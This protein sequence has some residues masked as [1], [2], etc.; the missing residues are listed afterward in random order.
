MKGKE[1]SQKKKN[2]QIALYLKEICH[3]EIAYYSHT[4]VLSYLLIFI[5]QGACV[6]CVCVCLR[7][8]RER[9]REK[10]AKSSS[11][12]LSGVCLRVYLLSSDKAFQDKL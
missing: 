5:Y 11:G 8:E 9:Q 6:V 1:F 10:T 3:K 4:E 7:E 12:V 2:P